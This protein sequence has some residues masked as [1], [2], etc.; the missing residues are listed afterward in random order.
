[1]QAVHCFTW[2]SLWAA[3]HAPYRATFHQ[4]HQQQ[5]LNRQ[6]GPAVTAA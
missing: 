2:M 4:Q 6:D 3:R 5:A 1:M